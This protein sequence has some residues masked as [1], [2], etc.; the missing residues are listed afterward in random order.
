[1]KVNADII[2]EC[3]H[4]KTWFSDSS[5]TDVL[6]VVMCSFSFIALAIFFS[7]ITQLLTKS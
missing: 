1:M 7:L 6:V 5:S 4:S 2:T 3:T